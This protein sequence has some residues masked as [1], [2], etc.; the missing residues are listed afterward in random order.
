MKIVYSICLLIWVGTCVWGQSDNSHDK[1]KIIETLSLET[2]Y[3]C[4]RKLEKWQGQWS[5]QAF[6]SK[7][8][9]GEGA[10]EEY[11]G[12]DA[13]NQFTVDH[14]AK[15]PDPIPLPDTNVDY[16]IHLLGKT[17]WVFYSKHVEGKRVKETRYMVKEGSKWKIARMQTLF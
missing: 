17:A 7:M 11:A 1:E 12:W 5:Q 10:Y 2:Q 16:D 15:H 14:I 4:G 13:I 6:T 3:F 8:Y 9:A